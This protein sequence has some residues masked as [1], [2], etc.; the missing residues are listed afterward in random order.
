MLGP[1]R[2]KSPCPSGGNGIPQSRSLSQSEGKWAFRWYIPMCFTGLS[3]LCLCKTDFELCIIALL[4][5]FLYIWNQVLSFY[6]FLRVTEAKSSIPDELSMFHIFTTNHSS[7]LCLRTMPW[8]S[9]N[10][11]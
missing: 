10:L 11:S 8:D 9:A 6:F 4:T 1:P 7:S 2:H 5:V 3:T